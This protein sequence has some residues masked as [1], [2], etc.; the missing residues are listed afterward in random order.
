VLTDWPDSKKI[1]GLDKTRIYYACVNNNDDF[2][3][4]LISCVN[5]KNSNGL[6]TVPIY[7]LQV[8][9]AGGFF[10]THNSNLQWWHDTFYSKLF[11]YF[12]NN[13]LVK[14]DQMIIADCVFS[15]Q[16]RF[17]LIRENSSEYDNWFLFQRYLLKE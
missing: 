9:I 1:A 12:D 2:I 6:P 5:S 10:I 4:E 17:E 16:S 7:P 13:Y 3:N 15:N 14:D 8:S 11:L